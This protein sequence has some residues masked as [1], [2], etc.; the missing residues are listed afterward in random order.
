MKLRQARKI[1][2]GEV[3]NHKQSTIKAAHSRCCRMYRVQ[4]VAFMA[5]AR[6]AKETVRHYLRME[7][8][9]RKVRQMWPIQIP[10]MSSR[11]ITVIGK[12]AE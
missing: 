9:F 12:H 4:A 6:A 5:V 2:A 3:L 11:R 8:S 1:A 10:A 7:E